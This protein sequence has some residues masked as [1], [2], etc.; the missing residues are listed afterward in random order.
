[1]DQAWAIAN[2]GRAREN[3][4]RWRVANLEKAK[5]QI[6]AW[7]EANPERAAEIKRGW[8]DANREEVKVRWA[9]WYAVNSDKAKANAR[10]YQTR[11][12]GAEGTFTAEDIARIRKAQGDRCANPK[13]RVRLKGKGH[14]DHIVP[15]SRGGTN[16]P[17]NIQ[18]LCETCN[19]CKRAK[20][21]IAFMQECGLLL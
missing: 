9:A 19:Q 13:C 17:C 15:L 6:V 14:A 8:Y 21:P 20:D 11:K 5:A 10:N 18:L 4:A 7:A 2:P 16:W 12:R 1:M 3:K